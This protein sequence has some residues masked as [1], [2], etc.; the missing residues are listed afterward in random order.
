MLALIRFFA[1]AAVAFVA[2]A[3]TYFRTPLA[4]VALEYVFDETFFHRY[5]PN[6]RRVVTFLGNH[7]VESPPVRT[8]SQGFRGAEPQ[9]D[10]PNIAIIGSSEVFGSGVREEETVSGVLQRRFGD[11]VWVRNL[12]TGGHGPEHH[13]RMLE[14]VASRDGVRDA[15]IRV[16]VSDH[17]FFMPDEAQF[18]AERV[19][20]PRRERIE[21]YV[22]SASF[23]ANKLL[24]QRHALRQLFR[25]PHRSLSDTTLAEAM[26]RNF[27]SAWRGAIGSAEKADVRLVFY[28]PNGVGD[29][30]NRYLCERLVSA[31]DKSSASVHELGP[32]AFGLDG[33]S[34][35]MRRRRFNDRF[36][37]GYD[38]H[39][40]AARYEVIGSE[41]HRILSTNAQSQ[42]GREPEGA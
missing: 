9:R 7:S 6:Q 24:A 33:L 27:E 42:C 10:V 39:G 41:L 5:Q 22:A 34:E 19:N 25:R 18:E 2:I 16:A 4:P 28:I 26:W 11:S 15:V 12:G 36:T 14:R 37:L 35:T 30:N 20:K 31:T 17:V 29:A 40:N 23:V 13:R 8:N 32:T 21:S 1:I 3:E 38:P